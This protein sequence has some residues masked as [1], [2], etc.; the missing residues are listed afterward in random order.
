MVNYMKQVAEMLGVALGEEF[1]VAAKEGEYGCLYRISEGGIYRKSGFGWVPEDL[2]LV[3][4]LCG[5]K[6]I[7]KLPWRPK[8]CDTFWT[9]YGDDFQVGEGIWEGCASDYARLKSGMVFFTEK[10]ALAARSRVY[11]NLTGK[12]WRGE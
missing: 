4:I 1:K 10:E 3:N 5:H 8:D 11:Q 9:Y 12:E 6:E 2:L 7:K